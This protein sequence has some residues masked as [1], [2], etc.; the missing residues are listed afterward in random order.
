MPPTQT[1]MTKFK[2]TKA[3]SNNH[4]IAKLRLPLAFPRVNIPMK[5][6]R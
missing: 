1:D 2:L 3:E 4:H 6:K 5:K